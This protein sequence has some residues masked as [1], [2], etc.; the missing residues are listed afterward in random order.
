MGYPP[1]IRRRRKDALAGQVL[2]VR[3][4]MAERTPVRLN[5]TLA[6]RQ[7]MQALADGDV[8]AGQGQYSGGYRLHGLTVTA[9]VQLLINAGWAHGG[10]HPGLTP[11]G[12]QALTAGGTP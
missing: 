7:L 2:G 9:R 11:A 5:M 10:K 12:R 8:K 6:R 4:R 1:H 3:V